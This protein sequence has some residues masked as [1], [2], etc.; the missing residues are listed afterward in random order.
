MKIMN[1]DLSLNGSE[2]KIVGDPNG[3]PT[4]NAAAG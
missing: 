3:L 2:T 4:S 1:M